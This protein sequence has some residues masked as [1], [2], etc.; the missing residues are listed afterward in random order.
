[1]KRCGINNS[2]QFEDTYSSYLVNRIIQGIVFVNDN[3]NPKF[4]SKNYV[5]K[6]RTLLIENIVLKVRLTKDD[7]L[8]I[9]HKLEEDEKTQIFVSEE[10]SI[11]WLS[12]CL[13][14]SITKFQLDQQR[15]AESNM[16]D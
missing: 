3:I 15:Q 10:E 12:R 5:D 13:I 14:G 16:L 4:K 7:F 11:P 9:K 1:M 8:D 2:E 6:E